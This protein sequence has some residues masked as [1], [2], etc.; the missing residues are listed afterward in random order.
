MTSHIFSGE[1]TKFG[2]RSL[3]AR[4]FGHGT[5]QLKVRNAVR[6]SFK[7]WV[8]ISSG[9]EWCFNKLLDL[10]ISATMDSTDL[11]YKKGGFLGRL[12]SLITKC[13]VE[14]PDIWYK[15]IGTRHGDLNQPTC[16]FGPLSMC[17]L[18]C[19]YGMRW[20]F[21]NNTTESFCLMVAQAP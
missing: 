21:H 7:S 3:S 19:K 17:I 6:G 12:N 14:M 10:W 4:C 13:C 2:Y 5:S 8:P 20:A 16:D 9:K 1:S 18:S 11:T 15:E